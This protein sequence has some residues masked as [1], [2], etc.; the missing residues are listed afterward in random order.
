MR[1]ITVNIFILIICCMGCAKTV[2]N[3]TIVPEGG[4][5]SP[6]SSIRLFNLFGF[7]MDVSVN[8]IPLTS[9]GTNSG[10]GQGLSLF[11]SGV[12]KYGSSFTIPT[13]LLDKAGNAHIS[14]KAIGYPINNP[15]IP[16]PP[17]TTLPN[18]PLQPVDYYVLADGRFHS[19]PR[20]ITAPP[21]PSSFRIRVINLGDTTDGNGLAGPVS[22]TYADGSQVDS[23]LDN[24]MTGRSSDYVDIPYGTYE[25]KLFT[26]GIF[27]KQLTE[28]PVQPN[29]RADI[30]NGGFIYYQ[31]QEARFAPV[32]VFKP[33]G[34][35][36]IFV[37]K[38]LYLYTDQYSGPYFIFANGYRI[39]AENSP[40][41]NVTY[42]RIQA[43]NACPVDG[44]LTMKIDGQPLG[45]PLDY[46]QHTE[47][48]ILVKGMHTVEVDDASGKQLA[49]KD[50]TLYPYD[51][52][53]A[54]AYMKNDTADIC[55]SATDMS[56]VGTNLQFKCLNLCSGLPYLTFTNDVTTFAMD[57]ATNNLPL[58]QPVLTT[59][60]ER[61]DRGIYGGAA[62]APMEPGVLSF[63]IR[64]FQSDV[65]PPVILPGSYLD[66]VTR[67][68]SQAF[69]AN[70]SMYS[71]AYTPNPPEPGAYTMALIGRLQSESGDHFAPKILLLKHNK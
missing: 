40:S 71:A 12:W 64:A 13:T 25:F 57:S 28:A 15:N 70:P 44:A 22:L 55:F 62:G 49:R 27:T 8:N 60:Y 37:S 6:A 18:N 52:I 7:D 66:Q 47:Y 29:S 2:V 51:N 16:K 34:F 45:S 32:R 46:G 31:D 43:V 4:I 54:W 10:I 1:L 69:V 24:I 36:T 20:S 9:Y 11:P 56:T 53:S 21:D 30:F 58:G 33:G 14:L 35:Y 23:R 67:L 61:F 41:V 26:N 5:N 19:I 38:N 39:L 59:P 17:D 42:A 65:G 50:I 3:D 68:S 48:S 63:I